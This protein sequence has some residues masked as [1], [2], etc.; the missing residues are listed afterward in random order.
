M[1]KAK[2]KT[3]AAKPE[4]TLALLLP[5]PVAGMAGG[6]WLAFVAVSYTTKGMSLSGRDWADMAGL[7]R[8]LSG[9]VAGGLLKDL[10]LACGLWAGAAG[11]GGRLR[12]ALTG[13]ACRDFSALAVDAGLGLGALSLLLLGLGCAGFF[14]AAALRAVYG[15]FVSAGVA[16]L[17]LRPREA[18]AAAE[19]AP[20]PLGPWAGAGLAVLL[21]CAAL[22]LLAS[23]APEVFYDSLVYHLALPKLY[24]LRGAVVPTPENVYSGLPQGVQ[25]L[26]GLALAVSGDRLASMLHALFGLAAAA[27]LYACVG[28]LAGRRTGVLAALL[29]YLCPVVVY[30]SWAC[31]VDL[32]SAFYVVAAVCVLCRVPDAPAE[33]ASGMAALAGLLAAWAAG[34]KFNTIPA[35]GALVLT[36]LWLE[37]RAGRGLGATALMAGVAACGTMP[38]FLKNL[39]F[40]GNPLYPFLH[41]RV[42]TL[43]PADWQGFIEAAG[44]RDLHAAFTT[45][46]GFWELI[47]LPL[48]CSLGTWPLGDWSG[49]VL[50]AL[51]PAAFALRWR[52]LSADEDPPAVWRV[53]AAMALVGALAWALAS[54]L[55]RYIV[56][57]LPLVAAT[58]AL[59]VERGAWPRWLNRAAWAGALTGSL[60]ALQCVY[61]QGWGIGQ[62][63]YLRGKVSREAYLHTQRVTYGLPYYEAAAWI[64][65]NTPAGSKVLVLGE[66][67]GYYLERDFIAATVYDYNPFWTE[68]ALSKDEDDLRARLA[69]KGVTH[70]L[71]SARQLH[72]RS[73]AHA[74]LPREL[75]GSDMLDR[76]MRNWAE[77]LWEDRVDG[78]SQPRWL[79][80][81]ALRAA[82]QEQLGFLN[83]LRVVLD[84]LARQ[85]V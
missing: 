21:V 75:A 82:P 80:V 7:F 3:P 35:A 78:G 32:A 60:L 58:T 42:G 56:P 54:S 37:R 41:G 27:A 8:G 33:R 5:V 11:I 63:E 46:R 18:G 77:R 13:P 15:L 10:L 52:W 69:A 23:A 85:G 34:T 50:V 1:R 70:I 55:V 83:P 66:S 36:H 30:A 53:V 6:L 84:V 2:P 9:P 49:P 65:A 28:R 16:F 39:A 76:F 44:S 59:A 14:S 74:V 22:N 72:F 79:I 20:E 71:L 40:Y 26:F 31:G 57:S 45:W 43:R 73:A 4:R 24:L 61:R 51:T 62:W 17:A 64:N 25:M 38:W 48:R 12:R 68:A 67:R 19:K 29:F 47:S 81:Y